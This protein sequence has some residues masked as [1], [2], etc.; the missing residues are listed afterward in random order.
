M[1]KKT[2]FPYL[3]LLPWFFGFIVFKLNPFLNAIY[4]S[5]TKYNLL[6]GRVKFIA[7]DH[8][9]RIFTEDQLFVKSI[10]ATLKYVL[11]SVPLVLVFSL[12]VAM[13]LNTKLKG[14]HFFRTAYYIPSILGGNVAIATLW[15]FIFENNGLANGFLAVFGIAPLSWYADPNLAL[16]VISLLRVWQF[17]STMVIFLAALQNA[18][19]S[20]YEAASIDGASKVRQFF[21]ITLPLL[22]PVILFNFV[23]RMIHAFQEFNSAFL[24]TDGGPLYG[25]YLFNLY[26]YDVAFKQLNMGYANALSWILFTMIGV[27]TLLIFRTSKYWVYYSE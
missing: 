6:T 3:L 26:I 16:I 5:L 9:I 15:R 7:F 11:Y 14:V 21:A 20:I 2:Y 24:I 1:K 17:G 23:M 10:V 19:R 13:I 27:L 25:T 18:P 12:L 4:L 8:Y 22:T